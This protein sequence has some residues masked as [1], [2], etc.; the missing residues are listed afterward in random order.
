MIRM[1]ELC[2]LAAAAVPFHA[3]NASSQS[4]S[5]TEIAIVRSVDENGDR[6]VELLAKTVD[7][8]SGTMNTDGVRRV[9][10]I[11]AD[12]LAAL[13]FATRWIDGAAFRRAGHLIA[14]LPGSGTCL[15]LIGHLDTVFEADSPFQRFTIA[16]DSARGPGTIDMKG[17]DVIIVE[18]LRALRAAGTLDDACITVIMTGDEE[19]AGRPLD[20]ARAALVEAAQRSDVSL[21]FEDG[22]GNPRTAVVA[23]R[24]ASRWLLRVRGTPAH[25]SQ[26]FQPEYGSGAIYEASRILLAFHDELSGWEDLT[27]NPGVIV[28]GTTANFDAEQGRGDAFG[29]N[30]VIA[31]TAIVSGDLRAVSPE[32]RSGA[33][34][35]MREIVADHLPRTEAEIEFVHS[36]PP[37]AATAGNLE[38]LGLYDQVSRDL[39]FG[40]VT[41]V[42]PRAAGA[43]D[44]SFTAGHVDMALDGLGLMGTGGHTVEETADLGTLPMQTKR[45]AILIYRLTHG[46]PGASGG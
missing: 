46:A 3:S 42:D 38:L 32:Q 39:G 1:R 29:K 34:K 40:S 9:G 18:A 44:V 13:G 27:F 31:G 20:L 7:V 26:I 35:R 8:N 15:L 19:K 10:E 28:G 41:A 5:P 23:R 45:A 11:F 33:E 12:Q 25:S 22:D 17:G 43:A 2:L 21:G 30:N 24:G 37:M 6:A 16:G 14:T 4:L 36:Y